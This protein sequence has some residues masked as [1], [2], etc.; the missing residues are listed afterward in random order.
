MRQKNRCDTRI[1][2][3]R[4]R[5]VHWYQQFFDC[6]AGHDRYNVV[7]IF[8]TTEFYKNCWHTHFNCCWFFFFFQFRFISLLFFFLSQ[9]E[10][11]YFLVF[12]ANCFLI[13]LWAVIT[14]LSLTQTE[15]KVG[16]RLACPTENTCILYVYE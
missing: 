6:C 8:L 14:T 2:L 1:F 4:I 3:Y 5:K 9:K 10:I 13:Y 12:G 15:L 7:C 16:N 11:K